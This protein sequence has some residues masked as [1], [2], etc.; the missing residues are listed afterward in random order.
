MV[1]K[2]EE[3][4]G[5]TAVLAQDPQIVG[6]VGAALFARERFLQKQNGAAVTA[7]AGTA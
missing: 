2:I 6:A 5:V 3:K 7:S 4:L 1:A